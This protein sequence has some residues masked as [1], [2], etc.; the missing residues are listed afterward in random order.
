MTLC[1]SGRKQQSQLGCLMLK[2]RPRVYALRRKAGAIVG[3]GTTEKEINENVHALVED[4]KLDPQ[5]R[6]K[7]DFSTCRSH[8]YVFF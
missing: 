1:W 8:A 4:P 7:I 2:Q 5:N 6:L 3:A